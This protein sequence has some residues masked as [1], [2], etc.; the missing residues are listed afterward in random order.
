MRSKKVLRQLKKS[1]EQELSDADILRFGS[2][3][4]NL[5]ETAERNELIQFFSGFPILLDMI[6]EAYDQM[7]KQVELAQRSLEISSKELMAVN[8][9]LF[10]INQTFDAM[11]NSLGQGFFL[12]DINGKIDSLCSKVCDV[13]LEGSPAGKSV[14]E[15]LKV[16]DDKQDTFQDWIELLFQETLEF[17]DLALIGQKFFPHSGG[18]IVGLEYK[19]VRDKMGKIQSVVVIATDRTREIESDRKAQGMQAYATLVVAILKDRTRFRQYVMHSRRFFQEMHELLNL[20]VFSQ[21]ALTLIK[22]HLHTLK[23]AAGTFGMIKVK[24]LFHEVESGLATKARLDEAQIFL[25]E[26][27]AKCEQLFEN[28]L[29]EHREVIGDVIR[30]NKVIREVNL[31]SLN[32]FAGRLKVPNTSMDYVY[33]SFVNEIL[34]VPVANVLMQFDSLV[35]QTAKTLRKK[36]LALQISGDDVRILPERYGNVWENLEHLFR[37]LVDHGIEATDLRQKLGKPEAGQV[38]I[39]CRHLKDGLRPTMEI[40]IS[41]DGKGIDPEIVRKKLLKNGVIA[42]D[43]MLD[44]EL[45]H[46]VFEAG[47]STAQQVTDMSGRG[48]GLDA[49]KSAVT[50]MGGKISV[51]S[52]KGQGTTFIISL[53]VLNEPHYVIEAAS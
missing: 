42:A 47:F 49:L 51:E 13:L 43:K 36:V 38:R 27:T 1:F 24:E 32:S 3:I 11:V 44:V 12:F 20:D 16:P 28:V 34:C 52:T 4:N 9:S 23:G 40:R 7:T 50:E 18:W 46:Q 6:D 29:E 33:N 26:A 17:D 5:P 45:I 8:K 30:E 10:S 21:D 2:F 48:V 22:R 31:D 39:A 35:Q 15:A 25:F 53:P 19:P 37:N 14:S 41:D